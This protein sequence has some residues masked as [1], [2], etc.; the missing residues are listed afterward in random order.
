MASRYAVG[1]DFDH[2]LGLDNMLERTVALEL[3]AK[4]AHEHEAT[5]D[6]SGAD[7]AID[8]VLASYRVGTL[9]PE[10]AFAGLLERFV[11]VHGASVMD[12]ASG[13]RDAVVARASTTI[14]AIDGARELL[15]SLA[16]MHVPVALLTN[17]WSPFQEEKARVIGFEGPVFVSERIGARKP[18]PEA[19]SQL[20]AT[21]ERAPV[22]I[23]YVGDDPAIDCVGARE[24]GM[25]SVWFDWENRTYPADC[26]APDYT[27][28][29]LAELAAIVQG[30]G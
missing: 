12:A 27:I 25:T 17:G 13:F 10:I 14:T 18:S 11:P 24:A 5:Y 21:F 29:H 3:L 1:F 7:G 16:A 2:T 8:D 19:F 30:R 4:Y 28:K 22:D 6:V 23:F 15:A 20:V 26:A 9:T